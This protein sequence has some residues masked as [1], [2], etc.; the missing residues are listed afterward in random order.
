MV[1][2]GQRTQERGADLH[3]NRSRR[4]NEQIELSRQAGERLAS[5]QRQ[6]LLNFFTPIENNRISS[7][8]TPTTTATAVTATTDPTLIGMESERTP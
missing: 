4:T 6:E 3:G 5:N 1:R 8:A 2:R 7:S